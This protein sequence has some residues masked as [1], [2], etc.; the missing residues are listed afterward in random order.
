MRKL[1]SRLAPYIEAH[2]REKQASGFSFEFQSYILGTFDRFVVDNSFDDGTIGRPLVLAWSEIRPTE[3]IN[4]RNQRVSF[5][6]QLALFMVSLGLEAYV[7]RSSAS[8]ATT[9]PHILSKEELQ[10]FFVVVDSFI[11]WQKAYWRFSIEYPILIRLYYCCGLSLAEGCHLR[12]QDVDL[13]SGMLSIIHSKGDKDRLVYLSHDLLDACKSYDRRMEEILPSR[14]W[15]FPGKDPMKSFLKNS[16]DL[17]FAQFWEKTSFAG[18]VDKTPTIHCLR[19]SHVV[20]RMNQ[21]MLEGKSLDAMMPY[22]CKHLGHSNPAETQMYY[23]LAQSAAP[24]LS[25]CDEKYSRA[26]PEVQPYEE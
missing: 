19:H 20:E 26:I 25:Q 9:V 17:R 7:P 12:R 5:V 3:S 8:V 1:Q 18:K 6:R 4:Y 11:P 15:F 14:E 23:H 13:D 21:W 22:L 2:I 24:I 10:E 16:L